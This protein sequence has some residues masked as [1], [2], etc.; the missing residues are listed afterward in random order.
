M[1]LGNVFRSAVLVA[2]IA[3]LAPTGWADARQTPEAAPGWDTIRV[4]S[5]GVGLSYQVWWEWSPLIVPTPDGGAWAFFSAVAAPPS[6]VTPTAVGTQRLYAARFD[7][8]R[9]V[10]LPATAFP[11]GEIQ[12]GPAA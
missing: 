4:A 10:W 8:D 3:L 2:A 9:N 5:D 6:S 7:P 11:G 1:K 12:F